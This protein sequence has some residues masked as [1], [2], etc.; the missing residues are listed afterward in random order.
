MKLT[1]R[2]L[3]LA[4]AL[5]SSL[6]TLANCLVV[7][8]SAQRDALTHSTLEANSPYAAKVASS[9]GSFLR[10]AH[11]QL[12]YSAHRMAVA[13]DNPHQLLDETIRLR[14]QG[15]EFNALVVTDDIGKVLHT[16]PKAPRQRHAGVQAGRRKSLPRQTVVS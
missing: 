2:S 1:L 11:Q 15:D 13:F 16:S 6:A 4:F 9:V 14:A 12:D 10:S 5:F 7:A 3:M 8:Y